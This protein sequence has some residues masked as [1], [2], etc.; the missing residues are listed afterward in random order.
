MAGSTFPARLRSRRLIWSGWK[1]AAFTLLRT[2]GAAA[3]TARNGMRP[4]CFT[5]NKMCSMISSRPAQYLIDN[6]F[7]STPKLAIGGG[8]NGG[9]LVGAAMTQRPDLFGAALPNVGVMDMLRFQKFTIGWAWTSDY[10]SVEKPDDFAYLYAYSP[11]HHM[12]KGCCYPATLIVTADH[13]D[14]VVPSHSFKFAAALQAAQGCDKPTL[15]R[16][17]TQASHGYRPTDKLIAEKAD[18]LAF[19]ASRLGLGPPR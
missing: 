6:K 2:C 7:T 13:D 3:S 18:V 9:L 11:L 12:T 4:G 19:V 8:S 10:G 17:E 16:V 15:I 14:R 1:W 5:R